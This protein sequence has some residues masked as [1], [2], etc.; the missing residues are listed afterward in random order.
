MEE[1]SIENDHLTLTHATFYVVRKTM[2]GGDSS[3]TPRNRVKY[4]P[5]TYEQDNQLLF[6]NLST[7]HQ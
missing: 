6:S 3:L 1:I 5:K 2:V 4:S 7:M